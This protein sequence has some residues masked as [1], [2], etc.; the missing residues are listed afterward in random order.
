MI[1][2]DLQATPEDLLLHVHEVYTYLLSNLD[3]TSDHQDN[4][5]RRGITIPEI[6]KA[7]Y[8]SWP[9]RRREIIDKCAKTFKGKLEGVPG[10]WR[11]EKGVWQLGGTA[12]LVVPVRDVQGRISALKIRSDKPL[13][14]A[15]KYILVSSS[16]AP[17]P[18]TGEV[19]HP[20]GTAARVCLHY[21]L[22]APERGKVAVL[23][24]TEGELKADIASGLTD[25]FTVSLP[26]VRSWKLG[27]EAVKEL[28]PTERVVLSFDY[29][30]G[31]AHSTSTGLAADLFE[32]GKALAS[33]YF[34]LRDEGIRVAIEDWPAEAGK[35]I[36]DVLMNAASD[37]IRYVEG[38]E[39]DAFCQSML[40]ADLPEG[41]VYVVGIKKFVH[42][43]T[44]QELDKEQFTDRY[45]HESKQAALKALS[46]PAMPKADYPVYL[47]NRPAIIE[48]GKRRLMNLWRPGGLEPEEGD[49]GPFLAHAELILPNEEERNIMLDWLAFN[50]QF[51]GEKIHWA[52][53]IQG[54]QG[55]G[56]SYF[57]GLMSMM[58]GE[59][60]VSFP[61]NEQMHEIYTDWQK[62]CSLVV[63]EEMMARAR[64]ELMNKLKPIITQPTTM[65]RE[66][67]TPPYS[68]PNVLN[69]L[70][71]S[72]YTNA[73]TLDANDRRYCV[74]YSPAK[75]S[76]P[77][78]F[79]R[80]WS[81]TA[82]NK[83]AIL[84]WFL[85]RDLSR[86]KPKAHAPMTAGKVELI[87]ESLP[88]LEGWI[89]EM[90]ASFSWP[91]TGDLVATSHLLDCLPPSLRGTSSQ[92]LGR[93]LK[94][95]GAQEVGQ[96]PLGES[97]GTIRL[98]AV[99]DGD[100]K[101]EKKPALVER[102]FQPS[103]GNTSSNPLRDARPF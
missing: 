86:F 22:G 32:V 19:K 4:L 99:R 72:N 31:K 52:L 55:T 96:C 21:P 81:W 40:A 16:P 17:D 39:A 95:S 41:W 6:L 49:V 85:S 50:V 2:K 46:N 18:K 97:G 92:A 56:K 3:L 68:Q 80:L 74:M 43:D 61:T 103:A 91:F 66:M 45:A 69:L 90:V 71:F 37:Q 35:G 100:W 10:F 30:K 11:D 34:C 33:L 101:D 59:R 77:A 51:P 89:M 67:R 7:Q 5:E 25:V 83:G 87:R 102:Y 82:A 62:G 54:I 44:L 88:A 28:Q 93:A 94:A 47:P 1:S 15:K 9:S 29:D 65:V 53:L 24:I 78:Y 58:L 76:E 36:D 98:W 27:L 38:E 12:G 14:P 26:G 79:E 64:L 20:C 70:L 75:A 73:V 63:V 84:H 57:G 42:M 60:N 23:R 13:T 48:E 8:K